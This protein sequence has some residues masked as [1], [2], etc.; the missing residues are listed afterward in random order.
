MM[1]R[2]PR[3]NVARHLRFVSERPC[4]ICGNY[5]CD[6]HHLKFADGRILKPI[7]SNIGM[8]ADD[9]FTLPLCR[10]HHEEA[11]RMAGRPFWQK[12]CLADP[13][14]IALAL[15]SITGDEEEGDRLIIHAMHA[16]CTIRG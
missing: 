15:F 13:V 5:I 8:K 14:L 10:E 6:A 2:R 3:R 1:Q 9:R 16:A 12:Y 11:H 7:S 4:I